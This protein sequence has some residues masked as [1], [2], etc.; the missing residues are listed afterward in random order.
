MVLDLNVEKL[1]CHQYYS[2]K[3]KT[4]N[5]KFKSCLDFNVICSNKF[6]ININSRLWLKIVVMNTYCGQL[7][8]KTIKIVTSFLVN[9]KFVTNYFASYDTYR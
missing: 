7:S 4:E 2:L 8:N 6:I 5:N 3:L 9:Q 1:V